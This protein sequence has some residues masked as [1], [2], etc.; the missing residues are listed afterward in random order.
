MTLLTKRQEQKVY[1]LSQKMM[2]YMEGM[3]TRDTTTM[4]TFELVQ[5]AAEQELRMGLVI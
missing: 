3:K 5:M 1:C 2:Q 4:L